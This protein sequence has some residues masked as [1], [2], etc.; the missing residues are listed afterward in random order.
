MKKGTIF[1]V[2]FRRKRQGRTYYRKRMKLLLSNKYRFVVRK[3]LKSIQASVIEYNRDGDKVILTVNSNTLSK[4]GWKGDKGNLPSAYLTGLL[5]G[6]KSLEK[7]IKE[8]VPDL[9]F[10]KSIKGSKLYALLAGAIDAGLNIPLSQDMSPSKERISGEHIVKYAQ[11]LKNDKSKYNKQ[12][13]NY[14]KNGL[15]P[16]D[17]VHHFNEVKARLRG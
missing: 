6:K 13:S 3:S 8:V 4:L 7:G 5:A 1:T 2:T 10:N 15:N 12:F 11:L 16:E 14:I 17:L 9:G